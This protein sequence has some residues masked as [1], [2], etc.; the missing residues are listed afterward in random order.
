VRVLLC[1]YGHVATSGALVS[2]GMSR[3]DV[4]RLAADAAVW[5][6]RRGTLACEHLVGD[7]RL[8]VQLG[9]RL[10]CLSVLR[11]KKIWTGHDTRL[12]LHLARGCRVARPDLVP[13]NVRI[14]WSRNASAGD[15]IRVSVPVALHTAMTCLDDPEDVVATLESARYLRAISAATF[16]R[17]IDAAPTRLRPMLDLAQEGPQSGY[18][19]KSRLRLQ[20]AGFEVRAQVFIPGVGHVDNLINDVVD[21]ETDG[22]EFHANSFEADRRRDLA[23]EWMGIRTLRVPATMVD[24]DWDYIE[25]TIGR[26][27]RNA[28]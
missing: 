23:A 21:L 20:R 13:E 8:V 9:A 12:H 22:R 10:D 24:T 18:E 26:M 15:R 7:A 27:V 5:H 28:R 25:E 14:H 11:E 19:T 4:A 17:L 2:H 16:R 1:D 6:P 3:R